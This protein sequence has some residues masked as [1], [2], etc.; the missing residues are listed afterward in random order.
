MNATRLWGVLARDFA[1]QLELLLSVADL[2][3]CVLARTMT[4]DTLHEVFA[5]ASHADVAL[6]ELARYS[7]DTPPQAGLV[8]GYGAIAT[9]RIEEGLRLLRRC[10][11]RRA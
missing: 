9:S 1:E 8:L 4:V 3:I 5:R 11:R 6:Q 2:H 10:F 7:V